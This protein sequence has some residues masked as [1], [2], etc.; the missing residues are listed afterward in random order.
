MIHSKPFY[1]IAEVIALSGLSRSHLYNE[2]ARGRL[3]FHKC[4]G[5]TVILAESFAAWMSGFAA[6]SSTMK[7]RS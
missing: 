6:T 3:Q 7:L 1:T 5:R 2:R 4:G